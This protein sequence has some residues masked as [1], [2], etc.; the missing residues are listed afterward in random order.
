[1]GSFGITGYHNKAAMPG[2]GVTVGRSGASIGVISYIDRDYWPLNT[3][4]YVKNFRGNSPRFAYY[5]LRTIDLA[6]YN[7]GSAQPSLNRNY[8]HP[9]P[10]TFPGKREQDAI[11]ELLG[12]LDDKIELNQRMNDTLEAMAREIFRDWFVDC[13][14]TRAKAEGRAAYLA[15][16]LWDLF[17][18]T[19][20]DECKPEG[21]DTSEIGKEV[22]AVGGATPSTKEPMYWE[23][24]EYCWATPKD[25]SKLSAPVLL[26]T[27]RKITSAGLVKISSGLLPTGT[28]LLS[29]RAPIGY[30]AISEVPT[31]VNQGFI[32]MVCEK[33][34][35]N[36]F[37]LFWCYEVTTRASYRRRVRRER[38]EWPPED[39]IPGSP[40]TGG[41]LRFGNRLRRTFGCGSTRRLSA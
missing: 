36:I 19:L 13:G 31:A 21:W 35:P 2:P 20:T 17:P 1:M 9:I 3:C 16:E 39:C 41:S 24:G 30:L 12:S 38:F 5:S 23:D 27:D 4:L 37:V 15:P 22:D 14:P 11:A 32:A 28:V 18:D 25:L 6:N 26:D 40:W 34:L 29:S 10:L 33:R 7:S 8:I